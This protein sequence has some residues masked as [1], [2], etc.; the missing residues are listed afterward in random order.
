MT[1]P[2]PIAAI[3]PTVLDDRPPFTPLDH[4]T[5]PEAP[6]VDT[7]VVD[8]DAHVAASE[9]SYEET[10]RYLYKVT[11]QPRRQPRPNWLPPE[12]AIFG[13]AICLFVVATFHGFPVALTAA[14]LLM[15][16]MPDTMAAGFPTVIRLLI[17]SFLLTAIGS[18][19]IAVNPPQKNSGW[20]IVAIVAVL[21][22]IV[23]AAA[24]L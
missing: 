4:P 10:G 5:E 15:V 9:Q 8:N 2:G 17:L 1:P 13:R 3:P 12:F 7:T 19:S 21:G 24:V 11:A 18:L 6:K 23:L 14:F 22:G 16:D 20:P